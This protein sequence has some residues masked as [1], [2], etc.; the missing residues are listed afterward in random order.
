MEF[1]IGYRENAVLR[2]SFNELAMK[3]FGIEFE[4]WYQ[5]GY[6]TDKYIPYSLVDHGKVIANVS[7][8]LLE[9]DIGGQRVPAIQ[10]GT[11]MTDQEYR[12]CGYSRLLL[13]KVIEDYKHIEVM[14]L[15]ANDTV[16][17]FYPKFGFARMEETLFSLEIQPK[18]NT[19]PPK[20]RD[21]K[22]IYEA[23]A[24][25][26]PAT[27]FGT[28]GTEELLIFYAM[29]VFTEDIYYLEQ[30]Q[31]LAICQQEGETL[32][33]YDVISDRQIDLLHLIS[34]LRNSETTKV[35]FHY[36]PEI[37][38]VQ[39]GECQGGNVLFVRNTGNIKFPKHFKHP[40]TSQA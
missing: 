39:M 12:N 24:K 11:V 16:L 15:F 40:I 23:A 26:K 25:R 9:L 19:L 7:V 31:A 36:T 10:I 30:E 38:E 21:L 34:Q 33:L 17:D 5:E 1:I 37:A 22:F 8:N 18:S 20:I 13:E 3:T 14:Y 35:V 27:Q 32:H 29:K 28:A 6:W 2:N 4:D